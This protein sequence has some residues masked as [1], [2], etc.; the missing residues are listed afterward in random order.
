[1][2]YG[3]FSYYAY[4]MGPM[5]L[6]Y[7]IDFLFSDSPEFFDFQLALFTFLNIIGALLGIILA[8]MLQRKVSK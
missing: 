2:V 3:T 1:M 5:P 6:S 4:A 8:N 7:K